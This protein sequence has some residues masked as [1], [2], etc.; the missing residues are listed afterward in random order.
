MVKERRK[1]LEI[2]GIQKS[3][4]SWAK[5]D[6]I[7][8]EAIQFYRNQFT[9]EIQSNSLSL[10]ELIPKLITESN[11]DFLNKESSVEKIKK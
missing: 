5:G 4:D 6:N 2:K 9:T 11:N 8:N 7:M 10:V 3:N 1:R